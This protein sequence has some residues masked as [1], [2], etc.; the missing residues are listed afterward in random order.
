[1]HKRVGE[2]LVAYHVV[3]IVKLDIKN[4]TDNITAGE[5]H[6]LRSKHSN[7]TVKLIKVVESQPNKF[8]KIQRKRLHIQPVSKTFK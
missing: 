4:I 6:Q 1:M 3:R 7:T 2:Q 8:D 5:Q